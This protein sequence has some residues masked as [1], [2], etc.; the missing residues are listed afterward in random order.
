MAGVNKVFL[1]GNLTRDPEL[2]YTANGSAVA[3]FGIAVNRKFKQDN[4]W[5]DEVCFID[6]TVWGKQAENCS[7]YLHK[8]SSAHIEGRL[9][10]RSWET[11]QG[12]KRSKHEVVA[13]NIQFLSSSS[14][15]SGAFESKSNSDVQKPEMKQETEGDVPF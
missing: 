13:T 3:G 12:Q 14:K 15:N 10:F 4:E 5:K 8:G 1:L 7:E 6:I 2:R 9:S 11:E